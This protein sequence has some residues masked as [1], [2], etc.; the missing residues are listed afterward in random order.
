MK[1]APFAFLIGCS[2]VTLPAL[3][4]WGEEG[5]LYGAA[6]RCNLSTQ[7]LSY[8]N[9][10]VFQTARQQAQQSRQNCEQVQA[11]LRQGTRWDSRQSSDYNYGNNYLYGQGNLYGAAE[12]CGLATYG[13][14]YSNN[15][16][17][18][19]AR[20]IAQRSRQ[21]C[22]QVEA[23]LG[24]LNRGEDRFLRVDKKNK[25]NKKSVQGNLYGSAESCGLPIN[26]LHYDNSPEFQNARQNAQRSRQN[27]AQV[28][29]AIYG[30]RY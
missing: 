17:F 4:G 9:D 24:Q 19:N 10:P 30:D 28:Q 23:T 16:V 5:N 1:L 11:S 25:K 29:R 6:E 8:S 12:S 20:T 22:G 3:A 14:S 18:Q 7:G 15:N 2:L 13:L 21:D 26:G 27:C